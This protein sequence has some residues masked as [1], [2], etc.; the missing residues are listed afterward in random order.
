[1]QTKQ[2]TRF[3]YYFISVILILCFFSKIID[4]CNFNV[5]FFYISLYFWSFFFTVFNI[6]ILFAE[7]FNIKVNSNK[8]GLKQLL[9]FRGTFVII[10]YSKHLILCIHFEFT[11]P[12]TNRLLCMHFQFTHPNTNVKH[13]SNKII[14]CGWNI[15]MKNKI[16]YG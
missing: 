5:L 9:H 1:M 2:K 7:L 8:I 13:I 3:F 10:E 11:H 12:N 4:H 14:F 16:Y 15:A 6:W